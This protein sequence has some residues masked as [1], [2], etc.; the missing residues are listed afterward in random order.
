MSE[1]KKG[2]KEIAIGGVITEPGTSHVYRTGG[3]RT[4]RPVHDLEKCTN[5]LFCWLFC[6]DSAISVKDGKFERFNLD[7]CKG[8]GICAQECP[9]KASAITMVEEEK[10]SE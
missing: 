5:C 4:Y 7:H 3:W 10:F 6:P 8:C 1:K 9:P 2:W